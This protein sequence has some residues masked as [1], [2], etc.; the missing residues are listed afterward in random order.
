MQFKLQDTTDTQKVFNPDMK[1]CYTLKTTGPNKDNSILILMKQ[2]LHGRIQWPILDYCKV[3]GQFLKQPICWSL[4]ADPQPVGRDPK[5]SVEPAKKA[6][7]QT[8]QG[9]AW[10]P[11][12]PRQQHNFRQ[13]GRAADIMAAAIRVTKVGQVGGQTRWGDAETEST[14][15]YV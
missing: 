13:Q 2:A 9:T 3:K 6:G 1:R 12:R 5:R 7:R 14:A 4:K 8:E 15:L 10:K 11:S